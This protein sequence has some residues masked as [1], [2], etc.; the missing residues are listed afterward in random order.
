YAQVRLLRRGEPGAAPT[1]GGDL[2]DRL[3]RS[4]AGDSHSA[5]ERRR[6]RPPRPAIPRAPDLRCGRLRV[7]HLHRLARTRPFVGGR[8]LGKDAA[9]DGRP[10]QVNT[11]RLHSCQREMLRARNASRNNSLRHSMTRR[12]PPILCVLWVSVVPLLGADWTHWRGPWQ[13]G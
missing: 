5:P 8:G 13:D 7:L 12:F 10:T 1:E 9:A 6:R 3:A 11:G 4:P 2:A